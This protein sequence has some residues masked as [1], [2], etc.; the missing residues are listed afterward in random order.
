MR[1]L[2][3]AKGLRQGI[4]LICALFSFYFL[5][6]PLCHAQAPEQI[7][8]TT[9]YPS[10]YGVYQ[11]LEARRM[12]IGD[13]AP[14]NPMPTDNGVINFQERT[15]NP[16]FAQEG[17]IYYNGGAVGSRRQFMYFNGTAWVPLGGCN[18]RM[19][20]GSSGKRYCPTGTAASITG[21][22]AGSGTG[23]YLC[24]PV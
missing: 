7:T 19:Y 3:R 21:I 6:V 11:S 24:C 1:N 10:P 5:I 12:V 9:Y 17:M 20:T 2:F 23:Y 4:V 22:G 15:T 14:G 18:W 13:G 16:A 8:I